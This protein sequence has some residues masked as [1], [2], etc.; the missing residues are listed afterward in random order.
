[1][2]RRTAVLS[3]L[4]WITYEIW[5]I[6]A[7]DCVNLIAFSIC[8]EYDKSLFIQFLTAFDVAFAIYFLFPFIEYSATLHLKKKSVFKEKPRL[9]VIQE[10]PEKLSANAQLFLSR[11]QISLKINAAVALAF[12]FLP[13]GGDVK[14]TLFLLGY[15]LYVLT[16]SRLSI[17]LWVFN[18]IQWCKHYLSL[19]VGYAVCIFLMYFDINEWLIQDLGYIPEGD[20]APYLSIIAFLPFVAAFFDSNESIEKAFYNSEGYFFNGN[21][22]KVNLW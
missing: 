7:Y 4:L 11:V 20:A 22:A 13:N 21:L 8:G 17:T 2:V 14:A 10:L 3:L 6:P 16:F 1:M 12:I 15:L 19:I 18:K 9:R 5:T